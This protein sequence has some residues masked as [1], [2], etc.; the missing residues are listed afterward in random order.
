MNNLI[1]SPHKL[2]DIMICPRLYYFR[3]ILNYTTQVTPKYF[4]E[5]E[6]IHSLLEDYYTDIKERRKQEIPFYLDIARNKAAK[7][8]KG[9]SLDELE[10]LVNIFSQYLTFYN[11]ETT[12][13]ILGTETPFSKI[14][15]EGEV[16]GKPIR[17]LLQGKIDLLIEKSGINIIV[18]HK[19]VS[20]NRGFISRVNQ[21]LA[22]LWALG[23]KDFI[24]NSIGKQ[25]SLKPEAKFLRE[26]FSYSDYQLEEWREIAIETSLELIGYFENNRFPAR[27]T[28]CSFH[29]NKCAFY[30]VC[31]TTRDNWEYKLKSNYIIQEDYQSEYFPKEE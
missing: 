5:G 28:G 27:Y 20:Q 22:Y 19:V 10:Y 29:G 18:D 17:I 9:L 24:V 4:L 23:H 12:W 30:D 15:W 25:K 16:N 3:H 2:S 11:N 1:I 21:N 6:F 7:F 31:E 8:D 13:K 26:Y 14:L